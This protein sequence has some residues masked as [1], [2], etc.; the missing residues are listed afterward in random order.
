MTRKQQKEEKE[1][2]RKKKLSRVE[3]K[4]GLP[5]QGIENLRE[6]RGKGGLKAEKKKYMKRNKKI[7]DEKK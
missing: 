2:G 6:K 1:G 4:N 7:G 3:V 5:N